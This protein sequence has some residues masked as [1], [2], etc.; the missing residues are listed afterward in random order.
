[1]RRLVLIAA[2]VLT[3]L[4]SFRMVSPARAEIYYPVCLAGQ[5]DDK[6]VQ[7]E[8]TSLDQCRASASGTGGS[9]FTNPE[10]N[11]GSYATYPARAGRH[12]STKRDLRS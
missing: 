1:M 2:A 6:A 10:T 4:G 12:R 7:C 8:F 5:A 9:C 11:S 3:S